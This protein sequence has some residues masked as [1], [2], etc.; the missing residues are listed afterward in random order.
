MDTFPGYFY[1]HFAEFWVLLHCVKVC[2]H[3]FFFSGWFRRGT[4]EKTEIFPC[5]VVVV[6]AG[7]S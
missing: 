5:T 7:W 3:T 2:V 1:P 6:P 4:D